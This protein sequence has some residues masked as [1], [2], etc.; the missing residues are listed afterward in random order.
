[1]QASRT[2]RRGQNRLVSRV[3]VNVPGVLA[4]M[5]ISTAWPVP[6]TNPTDDPPDHQATTVAAPTNAT[7][8]MFNTKS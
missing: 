5:S 3:P 2:V 8:A 4:A 6:L 1:M 7:T